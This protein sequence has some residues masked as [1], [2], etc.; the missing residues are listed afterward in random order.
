VRLRVHSV[1]KFSNNV[2]IRFFRGCKHHYLFESDYDTGGLRYGL[3]KQP[4]LWG[5]LKKNLFRRRRRKVGRPTRSEPSTDSLNL[6]GGESRGEAHH[7]HVQARLKRDPTKKENLLTLMKI[8]QSS[9]L[10]TY[11]LESVYV[12]RTDEDEGN[13][14][15]RKSPAAVTERQ[16]LSIKQPTRRGCQSGCSASP[17]CGSQPCRARPATSLARKVLECIHD[18][19]KVLVRKV[20]ICTHYP[21][22][23]PPV[24]T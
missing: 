6:F 2:Q 17:Q 1:K 10:T 14:A 3:R 7:V 9:H 4:N 24:S 12:E 18:E 8:L 23:M 15:A 13:P 16:V 5:N 20:V 11:F 21:S 19:T 22:E